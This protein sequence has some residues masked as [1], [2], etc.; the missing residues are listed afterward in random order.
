MRKVIMALSFVSFAL[1]SVSIALSLFFNRWVFTEPL[2]E[3]RPVYF[4]RWSS[5]LILTGFIFFF[6][7]FFVYSYFYIRMGLLR[8]KRLERLGSTSKSLRGFFLSKDERI[9]PYKREVLLEMICLLCLFITPISLSVGNF[10]SF[11]M[12][13][14]P[15]FTAPYTNQKRVAFIIYEENQN[16]YQQLKG[17][18]D[19]VF[20]PITPLSIFICTLLS[21]DLTKLPLQ[22]MPPEQRSKRRKVHG[23]FYGRRDA[24]KARLDVQLQVKDGHIK[25]SNVLHDRHG[26]HTERNI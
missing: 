17:M 3:V 15:A 16:S 18:F 22:G 9:K 5:I 24:G 20:T 21:R 14:E 6:V 13:P 8:D 23:F 1:I 7:S 26:R 12:P 19:M 11:P 10:I 25:Q 4:S 2:K